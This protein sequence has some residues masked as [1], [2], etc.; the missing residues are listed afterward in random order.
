M[1]KLLLSTFILITINQ[2]QQIIWVRTFRPINIYSDI[3]TDNRNNV[4]VVA[5]P[6]LQ[7][8]SPDG[9]IIWDREINFGDL[10]AKVD[11]DKGDSIIVGGYGSPAYNDTWVIIKYTPDGETLWQRLM[12]FSHDSVPHFSDIAIDKQN[13]ILVT[14][15]IPGTVES[16]WL[17]YKLTP[18]GEIKWLRVFSSNWGPDMPTGICADDSLNVIVGGK[19]GIYPLPRS[20]FPQVYKYSTTGDSLWAVYYSDTVQ[21]N[22]AVGEL[23]VDRLG[24]IILPGTRLSSFLFKFDPQGNYLWRWFEDTIKHS[25]FR[26]CVTDTASNIFTAGFRLLL[27]SETIEMEVKKFQP[28]GESLWTFLYPL[29]HLNVSE[30]FWFKIDL[31]QANDIIVAGNK[32]T[33]VYIFKITE[34][35]GILEE[36]SAKLIPIPTFTTIINSNQRYKIS[37]PFDITS[38]EIYDISG[39]LKKREKIN[40]KEYIWVSKDEKGKTL[41]QGVYF[42]KVSGK[43]KAQIKKIVLLK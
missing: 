10:V 11:V 22:Y 2:A 20:W 21:H 40:E 31:D 8:Y 7:K 17:T 18:I 6:Y 15:Y 9:Q 37:L 28:D 16:K 5:F 13:N 43:E 38:I 14:G 35:P 39:K 29:G 12:G 4:I 25:C 33:F 34:R 24:N 41:P 3:S 27:P 19:R 26:S 23:T 36:P 42:F 32:D 30:A 1:K